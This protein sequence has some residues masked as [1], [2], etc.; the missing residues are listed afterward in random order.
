[1][2][3]SCHDGSIA[4]GLVR[5]R[6]EPIQT[7]HPFIPSGPS[8][9]TTDLSDDHPVGFRFDRQLANRDDQLRAPDLVDHRVSLGE[10]GQLECTAC[11]DPHNN[12]FGDFLRLPLREGALCNTCHQMDGWRSSAHATSPRAVPSTLTR[13]EALPFRSMADNACNTCHTPHGAAQ[14]ER[15]LRDRSYDLC[16]SCHDG[17]TAT[18][19]ASVMGSRSG[20][21]PRRVL[22]RHDP[23]EDP[24]TMRAHVDCVDCHNPHAAQTDLLA[25]AAIRSEGPLTTPALAY[26]AGVSLGGI[27][28]DRAR[29]SYEVCF[30][31][32][33]DNPVPLSGR[34]ARDRDTAGNIRR[35][36]QPSAASAHPITSP[37][38][39]GN[40]TPSLL[41]AVRTRTFISCQDCHNNPDARQLGGATA[42]GPHGSRY[43]SLLAERYETAD[44][45]VESP[46]TYALCYGCH[47][48]NSILGDESFPLHRVHVVKGRSSCSACHT[49]HGVGGSTSAH[50]NLINF[51]VSIVRGERS[52]R[53]TGRSSGACTLTCHNVRHVNFTYGP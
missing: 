43:D 28:I 3:L 5:N 6:A 34:I 10:R 18:D 13:G 21:K 51:D 4:L 8:D 15:L 23:A 30:R 32:H 31:C 45:T 53:D 14:P 47:D 48:R 2:C 36:F 24:R 17:L 20:H 49:P 39:A 7:T 38:R 37:S 9:L 11:H 46:R 22:D 41:P 42:N 50:S 16:I 44:F 29:Y 25:N 12:E 35:Q 27:P 1:M 52:F 40:E 19:V 33:A 26:T